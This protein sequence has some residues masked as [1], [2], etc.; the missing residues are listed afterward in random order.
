MQKDKQIRRRS[1]SGEPKCQ[2]EASTN[3]RRYQAAEKIPSQLCSLSS[4]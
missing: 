2:D 1:C 4:L 3:V